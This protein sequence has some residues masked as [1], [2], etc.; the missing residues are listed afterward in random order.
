MPQSF[1]LHITQVI[2]GN[3]EDLSESENRIINK[4]TS[5]DWKTHS[6]SLAKPE[7]IETAAHAVSLGA[8]MAYGFGNFNAIATHPHKETVSYVNITKGRPENQVGSIT[9]TK[10]HILNLFDWEKVPKEIEQEN[11]ISLI[12]EL[13]KF[14]PFGFRGPAAA[15]IYEHL[16]SIQD[17][18]KTVQLIAPGYQCSSNALIEKI[19]AQIKEKYLY[20]T[21]ANISR[22]LTGAKEE[23]AHYKM[24]GIQEEF[25][26]TPGYFMIA[27]EDETKIRSNYPKHEPMSTSILAFHKVNF[28]S[29]GRPLL[30]LERHG[31]LHF[32]EIVKIVQKYGFGLIKGEKAHNRLPIR[33]YQ[34]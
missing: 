19:L 14:G 29:E 28:D 22:H 4:I 2:K 33:Q 17:G 3:S 6:L 13:Y 24:E 1:P 20:I 21:S 26:G 15:H 11:L 12:N 5:T 23:P 10:D 7:D 9:T 16:T 34:K 27:H 32:D 25:G 8:V 30:T 18:V 31:S